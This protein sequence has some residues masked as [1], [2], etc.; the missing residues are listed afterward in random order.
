MSKNKFKLNR[1]GVGEL[2]KS[3]ALQN[4]LETRANAAKSRLGEGYATSTYVGKTRVNVS[5]Y[6]QSYEARKENM[7]NNTI[8]KAVR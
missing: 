8:L 2:L 5:I 1:Q 4:V 6:A 3:N 7:Q